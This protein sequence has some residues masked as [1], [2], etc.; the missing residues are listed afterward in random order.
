MTRGRWIAVGAAGVVVVGFIAG[1]VY[2]MGQRSI[3]PTEAM[4]SPQFV[5][6]TNDAGIN[7][8]YDGN[9][10]YF[11][12]GG[13]AAFDCDGDAIPDLYFAGGEEPA[14][15]YRNMSTVAGPLALSA[16]PSPV[17]DLTGVTGAYPLDIDSDAVTDLVILRL[18]ENVLLRGLGDC[19][20]ERANEDWNFDGGDAWTTAMSA[21]WEGNNTF[22]TLAFGNYVALDDKGN[23]TTE[24][25]NNVLVRPQD[26][27]YTDVTPL[28]PSWCTLSVLFTDWDRSGG[29]DLRV[30]NDRHYYRNGE[31]QLWNIVDGEQPSLYTRD[32]GWKKLQIWG[33]GIASNDVTGDGYPE[34]YLTSQG[35][36]K[37]QS[38]TDG[39]DEPLYG[40]IAIRR[41]VLAHRPYTGGDVMPSTAWHPEFQDVNSDSFMD[42]YV[43]K[44]NVDAMPEFAAKDPNNLFLGQPDGTFVEAADSAGTVHFA[45]TRGA[46]LVD[47]NLD[48][49]LDL[50]EVNRV[51]NVKTWR[52]LGWG[53][54]DDPQQMGNWIAVELSQPSTNRDAVGSWIEV[55]IGDRTIIREVMVGGGHA[56]GQLGW[57]HFGLGPATRAEVRVIWPDDEEGPWMPVDANQFITITRGDDRP[58]SVLPSGGTS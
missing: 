25:S 31:E 34:V 43:S 40:D 54:A 7:H 55:S 12:G 23:Q 56:G 11:V 46:A 21:T 5:E 8:S 26:D 45:R 24:C 57:S 16:V 37:L 9:W 35:D 10:R 20:F 52:N 48:G 50:V 17:T 30:A 6:V 13:V 28:D 22:P 14:A 44:G 2:A 32:Q 15:L 27:G 1:A 39:S 38:L 58:S 53:T 51:E 18:G 41:G 49:M 3:T 19:A 47:L 42:L 33:M 36:N 29:Q 4:A